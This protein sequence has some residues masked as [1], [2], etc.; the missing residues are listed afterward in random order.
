MTTTADR[1]ALEIIASLDRDFEVYAVLGF[2]FGAFAE[3][4]TTDH[5]LKA[6]TAARD[7]VRNTQGGAAPDGNQD[8]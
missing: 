3:L 4:T 8:T 6:L 5:A 1:Q 7:S 2:L